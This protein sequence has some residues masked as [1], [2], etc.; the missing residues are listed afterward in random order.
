MLDAHKELVPVIYGESGIKL[1]RYAFSANEMCFPTHWHERMELLQIIYGCLKVQLG[2][3]EIVATVGDIVVIMPSTV[4]SGFAGDEGLEYHVISFDIEKFANSTLASDKYI[5]PIV[6]HSVVFSLSTDNASL[7][8][9]VDELVSLLNSASKINPLLTTGKMYEIIGLLYQN[10]L[11]V[12]SQ[13]KERIKNFD[14]VL[15]YI[16]RHFTEN[17]TS[18]SIS[19]KFNYDE[20]YFCRRFKEAT[21]IAT[22]KYIRI[23]RLELAQK[24]LKNSNESISNISLQC[25]FSDTHYFANCFKNQYKF[26]PTAFREAHK[27]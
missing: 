18:K 11:D 23:L 9:T 16:N 7:S 27:Q 4:H 10:C 1:Y 8:R 3:K 19:Q 5:K 24:L 2:N 21:G 12:I 14:I 22:M 26:T 17:I 13:P 15:E 20:T 25:G 6:K